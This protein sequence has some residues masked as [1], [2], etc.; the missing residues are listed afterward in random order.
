MKLTQTLTNQFFRLRNVN[1][2]N[3]HVNF[4]IY[5]AIVM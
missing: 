4:I 1:L 3:L 5:V 2:I